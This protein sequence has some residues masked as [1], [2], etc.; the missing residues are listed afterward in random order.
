MDRIRREEVS[1]RKKD[2]EIGTETL[3]SVDNARARAHNPLLLLYNQFRWERKEAVGGEGEGRWGTLSVAQ[4][5]KLVS[6]N[7][8]KNA[9]KMG[10]LSHLLR[11]IFGTD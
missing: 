2:A 7:K 3:V 11:H 9:R 6:A 10:Y 5:W 8:R 4:C 1:D